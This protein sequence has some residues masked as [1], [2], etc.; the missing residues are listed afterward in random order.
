MSAT[1]HLDPVREQILMAAINHAPFDGWNSSTMRQAADDAE[2]DHGTVKLAFPGGARE[3]LEYFS[4]WADQQMID[5]FDAAKAAG[6][7]DGLGIRGSIKL[8]LTLRFDAIAPY[9]EAMRRA[10]TFEALPHN[11]PSGGMAIYHTVDAAWRVIGDTSTDFNFYTKRALLAG[12]F[13][14]TLLFWLNDHSEGAADTDAFLERRLDDV[15]VIG[16]VRAKVET[17][18]G[19]LP[20]PFR[21]AAALRFPSPPL[22]RR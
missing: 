2:I 8:A 21:L 5:R 7:T 10:V 17:A 9:R 16:K 4:A 6:E 14:A 3:L 1:D 20:N 22:R 13:S 12:A 11:A 18:V 15:M 19:R